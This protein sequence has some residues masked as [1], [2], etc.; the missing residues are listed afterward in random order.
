[1]HQPISK[2]CPTDLMTL[3]IS[4]YHLLHNSLV[5]AFPLKTRD[6]RG[7]GEVSIH[8]IICINSPANLLIVNKDTVFT[9]MV[10]WYILMAINCTLKS[11]SLFRP[12]S[13]KSEDKSNTSIGQVFTKYLTGKG[14]DGLL[15]ACN[16][17]CNYICISIVRHIFNLQ[18]P[19]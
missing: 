17:C 3:S 18:T 2:T 13:L 11:R 15:A 10:I 7:A 1:M 14:L 12:E 5:V 6:A 9:G 8:K 16:V 4:G 19:V